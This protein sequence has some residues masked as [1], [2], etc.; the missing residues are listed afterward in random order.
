MASVTIN[1]AIHHV[2]TYTHYY[3]RNYLLSEP[4]SHLSLYNI[5]IKIEESHYAPRS[6]GACH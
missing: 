4:R 6:R 1:W 5:R 2:D 3:T